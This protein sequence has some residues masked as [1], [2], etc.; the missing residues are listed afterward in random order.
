MGLREMFDF[1]ATLLRAS[2]DPERVHAGLGGSPLPEVPAAVAPPSSL[3]DVLRV[4]AGV[5]GV[6]PH[7]YRCFR[8]FVHLARQLGF[9]TVEIADTVGRT[10]RRVR[11]LLAQSEPLEELGVL[12]LTDPRLCCVP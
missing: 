8:L 1:D 6:L 10:G 7:D 5:L 11:Q 4:S 2:V 3:F 12:S 9:E